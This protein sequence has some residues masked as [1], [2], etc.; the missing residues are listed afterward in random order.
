[1]CRTHPCVRSISVVLLLFMT[2]LPVYA[3]V[4][5]EETD[6]FTDHRPSPHRIPTAYFTENVG[7]IANEDISF[8]GGANGMQVGFAESAVLIRLFEW[9]RH[10]LQS[11]NGMRGVLVRITFDNSNPVLPQPREKLLHHSNFFLG[12]DPERWRTN[13]PNYGEIVYRGLYDGIDLVY[14]WDEEG[15]KYEFL[16]RPGADP[17]AITLSYEGVQ[18]L[19]IDRNGNVNVRTVFGTI[20]DS[21]PYSFQRDRVIS[22][23]FVLREHLSLGFDCGKWDMSSPLTIDPLVY[24]TFLGGSRNEPGLWPPT[25]SVAVDTSGNAFVTGTTQSVDFPI[26]PGVFDDDFAVAAAK[27]YW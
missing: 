24:S 1:M 16:V 21:S 20:R 6:L 14:S 5:M 15:L 4:S 18:S 8:Y 11:Q 26:T 13:V 9:D 19:D 27:Y 17:G 12:S 2:F 10:L 22:C 23:A 25:T 3:P 7:Q